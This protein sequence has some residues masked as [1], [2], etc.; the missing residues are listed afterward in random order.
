MYFIVLS[1]FDCPDKYTV[2][3]LKKFY[4][5][6]E[7]VTFALSNIIQPL[8][9]D[10]VYTSDKAVSLPHLCFTKLR[11]Y[12]LAL[13]FLQLHLNTSGKLFITFEGSYIRNE[14]RPGPLYSFHRLL[15]KKKFPF[16]E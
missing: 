16:R 10:D 11:K 9:T 5:F 14:W 7:I 15:R 8:I 2:M 6:T 13:N 4:V 12:R 1:Q 3:G